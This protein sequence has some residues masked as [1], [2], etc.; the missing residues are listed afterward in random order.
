MF[1]RSITPYIHTDTHT[2][3]NVHTCD[4]ILKMIYIVKYETI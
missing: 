1:I 2:D 3:I 4:K